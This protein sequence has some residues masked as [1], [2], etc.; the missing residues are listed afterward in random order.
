MK[1]VK[2]IWILVVVLAIACNQKPTESKVLLASLN[3]PIE[4]FEENLFVK[5][6]QE[7]FNKSCNYGECHGGSFEP[8]LLTLNAAYFSLVYHPIVKNTKDSAFTY[9]VVPYEPENSVL[10]ERLSNCCFVN[11]DDRMPIY[12]GSI[13]DEEVALITEWIKDGARD[14]FGNLPISPHEYQYIEATNQQPITPGNAFTLFSTNMDGS[15][16]YDNM[17]VDDDFN[18]AFILPAND[19][20]RMILLSPFQSQDG[21]GWLYN[22]LPIRLRATDA[23]GNILKTYALTMIKWKDNLAFETVISTK[24]FA[25]P[26]YLSHGKIKTREPFFPNSSS[27]DFFKNNWSFIIDESL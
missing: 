23:D 20:V 19:S 11:T 3:E 5:I 1:Q 18:N 2:H 22:G 7:I 14:Q 13:P 26:I 9:R 17:R 15:I 27:P 16:F 25:G 6:N 24:G 8:N 21:T 12:G 10:N 4:T